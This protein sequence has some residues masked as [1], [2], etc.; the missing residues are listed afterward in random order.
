MD[1]NPQIFSTDQLLRDIE[2][3]A[4]RLEHAGSAYF[5]KERETGLSSNAIVSLA[6]LGEPV[7]NLP[8]DCSDLSACERMFQKLPEHRKTRIVLDAME[9]ARAAVWQTGGHHG[10]TA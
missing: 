10:Q 1:N 8:F 2:F 6:Y 9:Q 5:S 7:K 4:Q 3:L